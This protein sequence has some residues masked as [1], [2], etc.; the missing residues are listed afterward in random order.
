MHAQF[1]LAFSLA[2]AKLAHTRYKTKFRLWVQHGH[3][4]EREKVMLKKYGSIHVHHG[5]Q[6][7]LCNLA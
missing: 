2:A 5:L 1:L 4:K 6:Q 3:S 7:W